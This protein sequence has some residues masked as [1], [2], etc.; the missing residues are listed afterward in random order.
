MAM[1]HHQKPFLQFATCL[2]GQW[3]SPTLVAHGDQFIR[4]RFCSD[5]ETDADSGAR[6]LQ[7]WGEFRAQVMR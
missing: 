3:E 7:M 5:E 4:V 2:N 6:G 1:I